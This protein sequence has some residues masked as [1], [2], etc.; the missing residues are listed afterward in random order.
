MPFRNVE[1]IWDHFTVFPSGI[2]TAQ[3]AWYTPMESKFVY[4][5]NDGV[6]RTMIIDT[7]NPHNIT[8]HTE[9]VMDEVLESVKRARELH[10]EHSTNKHLA[11]V[12]MT[13]VE[14]AMLEDWDEGDWKKWLNDP[15]NAM[16]RVWQGTV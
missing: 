15:D 3:V 12:P 8:V 13:V 16:F 2:D 10:P 5:N 7:D 1:P 11:K 4:R 14:R 9:V 6:R